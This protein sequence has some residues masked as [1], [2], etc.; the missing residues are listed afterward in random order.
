V[1]L[2]QDRPPGSNNTSHSVGPRSAR[3]SCPSPAADG[4]DI[5]DRGI[6]RPALGLVTLVLIVAATWTGIA[7][8]RSGQYPVAAPR[9]DLSG[10]V[11]D[12]TV[13]LSIG[14]GPRTALVHHPDSAGAGA[15]LVVVLHGETGSAQQARDEYGWNELADRDGFVVAYPNSVGNT[16]NLSPAC[17]GQAHA[18]H[19]NDIGF[20][21]QLVSTI[22]KTDFIARSRVFAVGFSDG[23]TLAYT[24]ACSLPGE[25]AGI[26]PVAGLLVVG[27]PTVAPV[28]VAAVRGAADH[29]VLL[30]SA[31]RPH[32]PRGSSP[33]AGP[34]MDQ[35][36]SPS[37][38]ATLALFRAIDGCPTIPETT[39]IP[40]VTQRSWT[41]V[42][43]RGVSV[44]LI[45]DVGHV[46]PGAATAQLGEAEDQ[47]PSPLNATDWLWQH[48]R[49]SRSR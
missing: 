4:P 29:T 19:L 16:W 26:G 37:L 8:D 40:P 36:R 42:A 45:S 1:R 47:S 7:L 10:I 12:R 41:C 21:H 20:L 43:T 6:I 5:R 14:T 23:A 15:P 2:T 27:C 48:L 28:S 38:E 9:P 39:T 25:L 24:W 31:S 46:W 35:Q 32:S 3:S 13:T 11:G 30:A 44:A 18:N 33:A 17:C 49:Y 34:A 22:G